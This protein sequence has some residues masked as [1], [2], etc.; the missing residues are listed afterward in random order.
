MFA[1][2]VLAIE[3]FPYNGGSNMSYGDGLYDDSLITQ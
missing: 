2:A 3:K 1:T